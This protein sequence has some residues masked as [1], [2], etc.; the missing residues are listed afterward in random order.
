MDIDE[1]SENET[2]DN[3]SND[4]DGDGDVV[5]QGLTATNI[6]SGSPSRASSTGLSGLSCPSDFIYSYR[7][8]SAVPPSRRKVKLLY[9]P[10]PSRTK[11]SREEASIDLGWVKRY[12][13]ADQVKAIEGLKGVQYR[14]PRQTKLERGI[15]GT[16]VLLTEWVCHHF[17]S[18]L[19]INVPDDS[20][21]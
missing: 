9:V 20:S 19:L 7:T 2:D 13:R 1:G 18:C 14:M 21:G 15:A 10:D 6:V 12:L 4:N 3:E 5:M 8:H 17:L 16:L 11:C